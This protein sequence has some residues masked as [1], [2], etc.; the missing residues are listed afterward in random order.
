MKQRIQKGFSLVEI[1]VVLAILGLII[2]GGVSSYN[3]YI[4]NAYQNSTEAKL[5]QTKRA[6]LDYVMVNYHMPCPDTDND[7]AENRETDGRCSA[8]SG[9]VP[10]DDIGRSR[11]DSSDD[12]N[13]VF[14]YGVN[15]EVTAALDVTSDDNMVYLENPS[16]TQEMAGMNEASYFANIDAAT[17]A[18]TNKVSVS[19]TNSID[20]TLPLFTLE[21]PVVS[22][23]ANSSTS[24]AICKRE[25][26]ATSCSSSDFEV[27]NIPAVL[28]AFNENGNGVSLTNCNSQSNSP[29]ETEN[30]D[31]TT[32]DLNLMR[33]TFSEGVFDDQIVTIS[34]YEIKQQ[35]LDR[36]N[37]FT[38]NSGGGGGG[39]SSWEEY[40]VIIRGDVD[41]TND[42]NVADGL[43]NRFYIAENDNVAGTGNAEDGSL[44]SSVVFKTGDDEL[45]VEGDIEAGGYPKM[46][47]GNDILTV[48][49]GVAGNVAMEKGNDTVTIRGAVTGSI[50]LGQGDDTLYLGDDFVVGNINSGKGNDTLF[51]TKSASDFTS[52]EISTLESEF[53]TINYDYVFP[54]E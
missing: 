28:V 10:Y 26:T 6:L 13:H 16:D 1:S 35:V 52:D 11:A 31:A 50:D 42:L 38:L 12:W 37:Q 23:D 41:D 7:G 51:T 30:C 54:E 45:F 22:G 20:I 18:N 17:Y 40:D 5:E 36:L 44:N 33:Q 49:G 21:T 32:S 29:Q 4:D 34:S 39:A 43:N 24:F 8:W 15:T 27:Q 47:D 2:G 46:K 19:G 53:D 48:L 3:A 25:T 9:F 14:A